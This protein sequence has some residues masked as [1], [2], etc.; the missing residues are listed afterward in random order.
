MPRRSVPPEEIP[1]PPTLPRCNPMK[2]DVK[3]RRGR[4]SRATSPSRKPRWNLEMLEDR[5]APAVFNVNSLADVLNPP[6]GVVTLRSAIQM[7]NNTPGGNVINLTQGGT[8]K[9]TIP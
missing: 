1:P 8:Y 3:S 9:I 6:P 4:A 2:F 5:L 7:A